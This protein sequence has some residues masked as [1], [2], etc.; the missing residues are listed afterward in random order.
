VSDEKYT[1]GIFMKYG[2]A[3]EILFLSILLPSF[4]ALAQ[5]PNRGFEQWSYSQFSFP[6]PDGWQTDNPLPIFI[7]PITQSTQSHSDSFAVRGGT[8]LLYNFPLLPDLYTGFSINRRPL[9]F[10]GYFRYFPEASDSLLITIRM[11]HENTEVGAGTLPILDSAQSYT[12]FQ[13]PV[14]Y[15]TSETP[16]SCFIDFQVRVGGSSWP[17]IGGVSTYFLI[18]DVDFSDTS[19]VSDTSKPSNSASQTPVSYMLQQNYPNP[20]NSTTNIQFQID[21][22]SFVSLTIADLLGRQI[23]SLASEVLAPGVYRRVFDGSGLSSGVYF[24]RLEASGVYF[25]RL[26]TGHF[27]EAKKMILQK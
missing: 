26:Q 15:L 4:S 12:R 6:S 5:I 22:T 8:G 20:F 27:G 10:T 7:A 1:A 24:Y 21:Q 9:F 18:D 23:R 17:R 3:I 16:D 2:T 19:V 25:Y 14:R 11:F 13:V